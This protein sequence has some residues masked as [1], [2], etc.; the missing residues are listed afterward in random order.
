M[1]VWMEYT[2]SSEVA[3]ISILYAKYYED[4]HEWYNSLKYLATI[5]KN[6]TLCFK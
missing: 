2:V 3:Q 5:L 6:T 1:R 4:C